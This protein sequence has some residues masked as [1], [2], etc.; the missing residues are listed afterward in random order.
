MRVADG[1]VLVLDSRPLELLEPADR[2]AFEATERACELA[3]WRYAVWGRMDG[4]VVANQRWLAG[5]RHPRCFNAEIAERLLEVF[6]RPRP[7]I[8]GAELAGDPLAT[9]PVLFHLMWLRLLTADLSVVLSHRS[10]VRATPQAADE[11][12]TM[13]WPVAREAGGRDA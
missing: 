6:A 9:L 3:G 12:E 8:D 11:A 7:L 4:V 2:E 1:G 13:A 10:V 5:Y